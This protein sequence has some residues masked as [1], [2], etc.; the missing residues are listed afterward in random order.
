VGAAPLAALHEQ[1]Q[2]NEDFLCTLPELDAYGNRPTARYW[3]PRFRD[4]A[5]TSA[6]WPAGRGL[7]TLV[8]VKKDLPQL[9][10]LLSLLA[11]GPFRVLAF[12]PDLDDARRARFRGPS[13]IAAEKPIRFGPLLDECD[14]FISQ[15]GSA[16]TGILMSGVPQLM[17]PVHYEQYLTAR[18]IEQ[19][20]AGLM[21]MPEA[22]GEQLAEALR[23]MVNEP[24]FRA[25]ARAYAARYPAYSPAEQQRRIVKRIEDI[26]AAPA[27]AGATNA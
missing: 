8:Y 26:L 14:L 11:T 2:S 27:H 22:T 18:R 7:R 24:R 15:A 19:V 25:A 5:G 17:L 12:V 9:D 6:H 1:F 13:R 10:A 20:G 4:D 23:R 3:G 21:L 16:A